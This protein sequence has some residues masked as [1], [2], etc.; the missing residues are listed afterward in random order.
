MSVCNGLLNRDHLTPMLTRCSLPVGLGRYIDIPVCN[1]I[2]VQYSYCVTSVVL[3]ISDGPN[4]TIS[5]GRR[6]NKASSWIQ[7]IMGN[8]A[9]GPMLKYVP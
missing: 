1:S 8:F 4:I 9:K 6:D 2:S 3:T 7:D 5:K